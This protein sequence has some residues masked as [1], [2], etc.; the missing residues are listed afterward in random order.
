MK[1]FALKWLKNKDFITHHPNLNGIKNRLR[2]VENIDDL[3]I[4]ARKNHAANGILKGFSHHSGVLNREFEL[5]NLLYPSY[6]N[7]DRKKSQSFSGGKYTVFRLVNGDKQSSVNRNNEYGEI[8]WGKLSPKKQFKIKR[9]NNRVVLAQIM[10]NRLE[11]DK[12]LY[13]K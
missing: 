9:H 1:C 4:M 3:D 13:E 7:S 11:R 8:D 2:S 12:K 6:R 5:R 10:K